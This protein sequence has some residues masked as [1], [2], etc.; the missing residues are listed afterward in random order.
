M[1][2]AASRSPLASVRLSSD[3]VGVTDYADLPTEQPHPKRPELD[4]MT[5]TAIARLLLEEEARAVKAI[6]EAL[7]SIATACNWAAEAPRQNDGAR[8][9]R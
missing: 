1:N 5:P 7:P 8:R 4:V 9:R 6:E 3:A 2:K